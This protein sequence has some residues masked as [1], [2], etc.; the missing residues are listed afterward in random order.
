MSELMVLDRTGDTRLQ[1]DQESQ[2][3]VAAARKRFDELKA[4]GYASFK[5]NKNGNQGEQID[6]FDPTEERIV[7]LPQ[8]V[9]G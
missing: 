2:D 5:V 7:L 8:M 3:Q 4:K 9:G 1:W 6:K